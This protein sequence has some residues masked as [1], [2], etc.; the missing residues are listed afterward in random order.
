MWKTPPKKTYQ[1]KMIVTIAARA[2]WGVRGWRRWWRVSPHPW[3]AAAGGGEMWDVRCG[4]KMAMFNY[5]NLRKNRDFWHESWDLTIGWTKND[6]IFHSP[7]PGWKFGELCGIES[8]AAS[9]VA[10]RERHADG[11]S[12]LC[13]AFEVCWRSDN[14]QESNMPG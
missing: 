9:E 14:L 3:A 6:R 8:R 4:S 13:G 7:A 10:L 2:Q 12:Q 1:L 11:L 5:L